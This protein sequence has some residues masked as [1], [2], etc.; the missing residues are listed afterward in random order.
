M[1]SE[2]AS[3]MED[4]G[5]GAATA[6]MGAYDE[7]TAA[8]VQRWVQDLPEDP[9]EEARR[10]LAE[11]SEQAVARWR[12]WCEGSEEALGASDGPGPLGDGRAGA[13][14]VGGVGAEDAEH[15]SRI[16]AAGPLHLQY[17]L[18]RIVDCCLAQGL[19]EKFVAEE[20]WED[21][22]R[23]EDLAQPETSHEWLCPNDPPC[24]PPSPAPPPP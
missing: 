24:W 4:G 5:L 14:L 7:R 20:R 17:R 15:P 16:R 22:N 6:F 18:L 13:G 21:L 8:A 11:A 2:M 10:T 1:A 3:H 23:L 9:R 12:S 19:V